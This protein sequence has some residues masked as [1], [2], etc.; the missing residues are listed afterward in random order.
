MAY[1]VAIHVKN[2]YN[3]KISSKIKEYDI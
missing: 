3:M 2:Q 1:F